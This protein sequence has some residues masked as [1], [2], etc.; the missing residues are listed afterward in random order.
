MNSTKTLIKLPAG[1]NEGSTCMGECN[2][3]VGK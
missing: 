1:H 3:Q 2:V